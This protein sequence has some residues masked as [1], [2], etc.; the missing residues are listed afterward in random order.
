VNRAGAYGDND[1]AVA[2]IHDYGH[3]RG[4]VLDATFG[5]GVFWKKVRPG[6]L[7]VMDAIGLKLDHVRAAGAV[8][9]QGDFT[10]PPFEPRSFDCVVFDPPYKLNG[11]PTVDP[12]G[13]DFRYGV[14]HY[15]RW[16]DRMALIVDG[17]RALGPLVTPQGKLLVKCMDQVCSGAMR[18][19][20]DAVTKA[21]E[22]QGFV[23]EDRLDLLNEPREQPEGRG[24]EHLE[25]NYSTLLVFRRPGRRSKEE[26]L[27]QAS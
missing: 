16:Q 1:A 9:V 22:R 21:A 24:E 18:W 20:T 2:I 8:R 12:R 23:K 5:A 15:T 17:V 14:H 11:Q 25:A 27:R 6:Q 3:V 7:W 10:R 4:R 13:P 26:R 19:Q